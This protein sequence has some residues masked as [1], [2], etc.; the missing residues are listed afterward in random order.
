MRGP[1]R[2]SVRAWVGVPERA[3]LRGAAGFGTTLRSAFRAAF[4]AAIA[5]GFV[6]ARL[7]ARIG[8]AWS[9]RGAEEAAILHAT[10]AEQPSGIHRLLA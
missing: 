8:V 10:G 4:R 5:A 6:E 7:A 9:H 2:P 3:L 1:F